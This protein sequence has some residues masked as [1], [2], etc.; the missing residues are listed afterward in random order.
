VYRY[1]KNTGKILYEIFLNGWGVKLTTH[2]HAVPRIRMD[3]TISPLRNTS[4]WRG[5]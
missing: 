5:A 3:G 1:I 4:S 2:L